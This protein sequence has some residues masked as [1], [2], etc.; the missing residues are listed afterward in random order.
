MIL[1]TAFIG[2]LLS[3]LSPCV[4]PL[5]PALIAFAASGSLE[6]LKSQKKFKILFKTLVFILG[7]TTIFVIFGMTAGQIGSWFNTYIYVLRFIGGAIVIL[8]G[9]WQIGILK[10]G[11]L[12]RQLTF[13]G[14]DFSKLGNFGIFL[15]GAAF[16]GAWT[17]CVGPILAGILL[18]AANEGTA[19]KGFILLLFYSAGFAVPLIIAALLIDKFI[20][21]FNV[22]KKYFRTI[23]IISGLLMIAV[24][25]LIITNGFVKIQ[26][27]L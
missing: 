12:N 16:A 14:K 15:A 13:A 22:M 24:G 2:G 25:I 27:Q 10:I 26:S 21:F 23:E 11:F 9:L 4:L 20:A 8:F 17:P 19:L 5:I 6:T 7:F 18:I 3:F 1:L